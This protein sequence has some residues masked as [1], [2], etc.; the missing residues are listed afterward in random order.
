MIY[1]GPPPASAPT[2]GPWIRL[3]D[4]A[5]AAETRDV[6]EMYRLC[7][8]HTYIYIYIYICTYTI[9]CVYV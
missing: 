8:I 6:R 5:R 7:E 3:L 2:A 9:T 4:N 1:H